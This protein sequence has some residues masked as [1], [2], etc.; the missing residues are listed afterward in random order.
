MLPTR[1]AGA[2]AIGFKAAL[3]LTARFGPLYGRAESSD[4]HYG[5]SFT[6][7]MQPGLD[8]AAGATDK[9]LGVS[10][11]FGYLY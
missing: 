9:V 1:F 5:W 6:N 10:L 11:L 8:A 2:S 7:T 4:L 3:G